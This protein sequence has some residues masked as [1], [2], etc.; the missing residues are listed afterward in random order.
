MPTRQVLSLHT[1]G[2]G[3]KGK[4]GLLLFS[5]AAPPPSSSKNPLASQ[6]LPRQWPK[7]LFS[8]DLS[9]VAEIPKEWK[10]GGLVAR[11]GNPCIS[12]MTPGGL[13]KEAYT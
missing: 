3:M 7:I 12:R 5:V 10:Q 6:N 2:I 9:S 4:D 1:T 8:R 13:V 11:T